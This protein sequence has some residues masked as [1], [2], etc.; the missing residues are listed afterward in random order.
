M[1][2]NGVWRK[3]NKTVTGKWYYIWHRDRFIIQLNGCD[4]ETGLEREPF[5]VSGDNPDFKGWRLI[6][7][8]QEKDNA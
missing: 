3:G 6:D 5:E 7:N 4:P 2:K 8:F 1:A